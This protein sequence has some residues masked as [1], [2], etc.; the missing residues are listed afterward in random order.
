[1]P[2]GSKPAILSA[3]TGLTHLLYPL[4]N[5]TTK[6]PRDAV[7]GMVFWLDAND[8]DAN[9]LPDTYVDGDMVPIWR[10]KSGFEYDAN[11]RR[12]DPDYVASGSNGLPAIYYDGNDSHYTSIK[13]NNIMNKG[14]SI[15]TFARYTYRRLEPGFQYQGRPEL[16]LWFPWWPQPALVCRRLDYPSRPT[17]HGMTSHSADIEASSAANPK[18]NLWVDGVQVATNSTGSHNSNTYPTDF[19]IGGWRNTNEYSKAKSP[20][21]SSLAGLSPKRNVSW[22]KGTLPTSMTTPSVS[23]QT[24]PTK[25]NRLCLTPPPRLSL[26]TTPPRPASTS[27]GRLNSP[28]LMAQ[29]PTAPA[30]F[31][32][33]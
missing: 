32:H 29:P 26:R 22:L 17:Q 18:A 30:D 6:L 23:P 20:K 2:H 24:T 11:K 19:Q 4:P 5:K 10:D 21:S 27:L 25:A 16:A 7:S 31:R 15:F 33:G 1:M 8:I 9:D 12:G 28:G 14:N 13:F 3:A